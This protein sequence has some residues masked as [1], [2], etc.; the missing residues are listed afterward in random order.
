[1]ALNAAIH[2]FHQD[3]DNPRIANLLLKNGNNGFP[4]TSKLPAAAAA[5][6][7]TAL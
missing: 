6:R 1:M 4:P 5:A 7:T 3:M 2:H